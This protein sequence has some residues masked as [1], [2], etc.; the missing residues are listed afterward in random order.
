MYYINV[1]RGIR[2][3]FRCPML[4]FFIRPKLS[5]PIHPY[6]LKRRLCIY[7]E[8]NFSINLLSVSQTPNLRL[9]IR[10]VTL[11]AL[12]SSLQ[13]RPQTNTEFRPEP[14]KVATHTQTDNTDKQTRNTPKMLPAQHP[15]HT[16][17]RNVY[18]L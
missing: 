17:T 4:S 12:N 11:H 6:S 5:T 2:Y 7:Y 1:Y 9:Y 18:K 14:H 8:V 15:G 3:S 10:A 16:D 13:H